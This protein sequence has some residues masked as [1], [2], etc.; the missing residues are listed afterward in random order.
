VT[1]Y[2]FD[3]LCVSTHYISRYGNPDNFLSQCGETELLEY[4]H[5]MCKNT[6]D[7]IVDMFIDTAIKKCVSANINTKNILFIWK[8][9]LEERNV[10]NIL[11]HGPLKNLLRKKMAYNS[12]TD[13]FMDVTSIHLPIVSQFIH[14]WD[15]YISEDENEPE[16]EIDELMRLFRK[17]TP[18]TKITDSLM[19]ELI[20][21]FYPD[22]EIQEDKYIMNIRCSLWDKR[23]EVKKSLDLFRKKEFNN[24]YI[25]DSPEIVS[26]NNKSPKIV[27][28]NIVSSNIKSLYEAYEFY[29]MNNKNS[30]IMNS[31]ECI[32][33]K[34]Y[35][36][37]MARELIGDYLDND[38]VISNTYFGV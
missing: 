16:I 29:C 8:K 14:F 6:P 4:S 36:E 11:L 15:T 24:N 32:V 30:T 34:R 25:V 21:H 28:S 5:F 20:R 33:S 7:K 17:M 22:M 2:I 37:K 31:N 19:I 3:F 38:G 27:T 12:E 9:F 10:P 26:A 13:M 18:H 1:K 35:F 23:E